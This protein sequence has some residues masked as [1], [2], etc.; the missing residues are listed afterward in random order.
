MG[1]DRIS[2]TSSLLR[3]LVFGWA[4]FGW[5]SPCVFGVE[6]DFLTANEDS[7]V[8]PASLESLCREGIHCLLQNEAA[9]SKLGK[10]ITEVI[11]YHTELP[12]VHSGAAH[13]FDAHPRGDDRRQLQFLNLRMR[14]L[15]KFCR[16][17]EFTRLG[18]Q[19]IRPGRYDEQSAL[20][21]ELAYDLDSLE[22]FADSQPILSRFAQ[23]LYIS[24]SECRGFDSGP[25][26]SRPAHFWMIPESRYD[27]VE[28]LARTRLLQS[29]G[30]RDPARHPDA[31]YQAS[32]FRPGVTLLNT[33]DNAWNS[34]EIQVLVDP[35]GIH[36]GSHLGPNERYGVPPSIVASHE[37]EHVRRI[38]LG[39]A[40]DEHEGEYLEELGPVLQQILL[41]DELL[42]EIEGVPLGSTR[43]YPC[44]PPVTP[45]KARLELGELAQFFRN[46]IR[47]KGSPER[48]LMS[49]EA[50]AWLGRYF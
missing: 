35:A 14:K 5:I 15:L 13:S 46:L 21:G 49:P 30:A 45:G 44:S 32:D 1:I 2:R 40:D 10:D 25:E 12:E 43:V 22:S 33:T 50:L 48:A 38:A 28:S 19:P 34:W 3:A 8:Y 7:I 16:L 29:L 11:A 18:E 24:G 9:L 4:L 39:A 23:A 42:K 31:I 27:A 20:V 17:G 36:L 6:N 26:R 37:I 47:E 41:Q